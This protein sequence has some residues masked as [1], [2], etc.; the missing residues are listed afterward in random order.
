MGRHYNSHSSSLKHSST[1]SDASLS[2]CL[3]LQHWSDNHGLLVVVQV[4][5]HMFSMLKELSKCLRH[6]VVNPIL[7][8]KV[9]KENHSKKQPSGSHEA[10]NLQGTCL[11]SWVA[12]PFPLWISPM[13]RQP[14][15]NFE[16]GALLFSVRPIAHWSVCDETQNLNNTDSG[17]FFRYQNFPRLVTGLFLV[18]T[19]FLDRS[20]TFFGTKFFRYRFRYHHKK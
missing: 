6:R 10:R 8:K 19:F 1:N 16:S 11:A 5:H 18:P 4:I 20:G 7:R 3:H 13:W 14:W 2:L 9:L 12:S 17:T 15:L